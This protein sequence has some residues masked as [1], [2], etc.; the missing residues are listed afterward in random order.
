V[1]YVLEDQPPATRPRWYCHGLPGFDDIDDAVTAGLAHAQTVIVR[2]LGGTRYWAGV[3]PRDG[4]AAR[5][6][7]PSRSA[8]EAIDAEY[9]RRVAEERRVQEYA[10]AF[11]RARD[12]WLVARAP[13]L[14]GGAVAYEC[15]VVRTMEEVRSI[16]FQ[17]LDA[18]GA[19]CA[20]HDQFEAMGFGSVRTALA[21]AAGCPD[22]DP[23]VLAVDRVLAR[24][25]SRGGAWRR[26]GLYVGQRTGELFHVSPTVNRASIE[27]HGLDWRRFRGAGIAGSRSAEAEGV[28]LCAAREDIGFFAG[29]RED[30]CDAWA[31][32]VDGLWLEGDPGADGGGSDHWVI[33]P[34]AIGP[35]RLRLVERAIRGE[36]DDEGRC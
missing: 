27:E 35:E 28:F 5:P 19:V 11:A 26:I 31:V 25:R 10:E 18:D 17:E 32:R 36:R 22:D 34:E 1:L 15:L 21:G 30:P 24:E 9:A 16:V 6:W 20:A 29:M 23:W 12:G 8:R 14:V 33:V 2:T 4:T 7:P 13:E 3:D